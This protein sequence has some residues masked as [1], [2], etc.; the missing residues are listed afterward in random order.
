MLLTL[1]VFELF[2]VRVLTDVKN[3]ELEHQLLEIYDQLY[4]KFIARVKLLIL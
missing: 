1:V 3:N 2:K 4:Q